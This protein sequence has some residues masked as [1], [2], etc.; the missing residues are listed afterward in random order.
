VAAAILLI[1]VSVFAQNYQGDARKIGMGGAGGSDNLASNALEESQSD[2]SFVLP[3]GLIQ[4]AQDRQY[5]DPR[6]SSFDPSILLED[7]SNPI[8]YTIHR[9]TR[10]SLVRDLVNGNVNP[11]LS[12]YRGFVPASRISAQGLVSPSFGHTFRVSGEPNGTSHS[13]RLGAGPYLSMGTSFRIDDGLVNVL[14]GQTSSL[15]NASMSINNTTTGQGAASFTVGYRGQFVL[16][17]DAQSLRSKRI[18]VATDYHYIHGLRY[19]SADM[20]FQFDTGATGLLTDSSIGNSA[21][22]NHFFSSSGRGYA[23]DVAAAAMASGWQVA[24]GA[25]GIG[26]RIEWNGVRG[27]T[28][29]LNSLLHGSGYTKQL[30]PDVPSSVTVRLPVRYNGAVAYT[31][32]RM[33]GTADFSHGFQGSTFHGG[34]ELR[35]SRVQLRGGGRYSLNRWDPTGGIGF[36]VTRRMSFDVAGFQ[37][38]ANLERSRKVSIA[39]SIRIHRAP[40]DEGSVS[41]AS[42]R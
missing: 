39:A 26:N 24:V 14:S 37:T 41:T 33:S 6:K 4:V 34:F 2:R 21:V 18:L 29:T 12:T 42:T 25:N 35:V 20:K 28:L 5:F 7:L 27:E 11:D 10:S 40:K 31:V 8:H 19:D 30:L 36:N 3:L 22:L 38:T 17:N 15:S 23:V 32:N 9:G 16:H 13:I 1:T